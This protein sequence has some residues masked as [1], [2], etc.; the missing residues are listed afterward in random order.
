[1]TLRPCLYSTLDRDSVRE[2]VLCLISQPSSASTSSV[3]RL[4]CVAPMPSLPGMGS[5]S[6]KID[7]TMVDIARGPSSRLGPSRDSDCHSNAVQTRQSAWLVGSTAHGSYRP[8]RHHRC[9]ELIF[10]EDL[11]WPE[12]GG[13]G[14]GYGAALAKAGADV[15]FIARGVHLSRP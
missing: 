9:K 1:M 11:P 7:E 14:G 5:L 12:A 6:A 13:V 3:L 2:A 15:T 10:D 4:I 8:G